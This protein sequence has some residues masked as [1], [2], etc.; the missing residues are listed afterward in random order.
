[1]T[2]V[3]QAM[4]ARRR[5]RNPFLLLLRRL[6]YLV[7]RT[8]VTPEY[9][10]DL[11]L[12][13]RPVCYV[14]EDR[15]LSSLLVLE[16]ESERLGLPS[17]LAPVG[18]PFAERERA[19][20]SVI[21]NPNPL[22]PRTLDPSETL[23]DLTQRVLADRAADVQLVPVSVLWGRAPGSQD[24]L[25]KALFADAWATVGPLRQL[26]IIVVHGRQTL[27]S[28]SAP[29]SLR[30]L[31][32][33]E[34]DLTTAT[35]K[36]NRF[37]RFHF[38]RVRES[39]IG[40]DLSH[41]R[42][43][44]ETMIA[45]NALRDA[46]GTEARRLG[47]SEAEAEGRARKFAWEIASD[48]SYPV[49]RA[50][51]I[52]LSRLWRMLY[53]E[54]DVRGLDALAR[55]APGKGLVY[56]P[57]HRSHVDY[58]LLSYFVYQ[59]GLAPPHIAAGANLNFPVIGPLLRRGG[60]FFLR[61]KIKGEPLYAAVFREYLHEM[62]AKGFPIA[63]FIEGGRSR[64]GRT[65][66]PKGGLL[67]MTIESY[68]RE[69]PRSL[70]L[71][72]L[73]IG[74]EKLL[75]GRSLLAELEGRPKQ[76]ESVW[77]LLGTL[78][79]LKRDYGSVH[80]RFGTPVAIEQFL[81]EHAP[82][83]QALEDGAR[84]EAARRLTVPLGRL[85]TERINDSVDINPINLFAMAIASSPRHALDERALGQQIEWLRAIATRLPYSS[86]STLTEAGSEG[87]IAAALARGFAV[88][89]AN[90]LGDIIQVSERHI[91]TVSYFRNNVLHAFALPA[92]V[93]NLLS[94]TRES[95]F[96]GL[97]D[98]SEGALPFLRAELMV[99][100]TPEMARAESR[101]IAELFL[102]LGLARATHEGALLAA[103]RYSPEHAA[104]ELLGRSLRNLIRRNYLT[105][106]ILT[107]VG[108][109]H[110][111]RAQLEDL[112]Q[113]LTQRLS[114]LFEFAPP[115]FYERTAFATYFDTLL[116]TGIVHEDDDGWL[117][118]NERI[119]DP[120]RGFERLLPA[121][122]VTAIR[123][124]TAEHAA[125]MRPPEPTPRRRWRGGRSARQP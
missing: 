69:H 121:E 20:F 88:R 125:Q 104:L 40:P 49:I 2:E 54:T 123:R 11:G 96:D 122:A 63:Y 115:D 98:F 22:S 107:R 81:D 124:L 113:M 100:H 78:R 53:D 83:W 82:G 26:A 24:S 102:E 85:M 62:L 35:R 114:L 17:P 41:R 51:E 60:A 39:A 14:L 58:L 72:P 9:R 117:H 47:I 50:M 103:E 44:I 55:L 4:P 70:Q 12:D 77:A 37:L 32:E 36:A 31:V 79:S 118:L 92:L 23:A 110:L 52:V 93:A 42:N 116:E 80:M 84:T 25:L 66:A 91:A 112:M 68:M 30:R 105:I 38:R 21:V 34:T 29:V 61:R 65:L 13:A 120:Q 108:S 111:K 75:E 101:Q 43:L 45:S 119:R 71:V 28:F 48:F 33:N 64:S 106:A 19:V 1:M 18:A 95:T 7:V 97:A 87:V 67:G 10:V 99:H 76:R 109:G 46:I 15:H 73:Y 86:E 56:L 74:Y 8:Q 6:L 59:G 94:S 16:E 89:V 5:S 57:N 27:V 3:P 90:P